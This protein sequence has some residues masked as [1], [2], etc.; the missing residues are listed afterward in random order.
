MKKLFLNLVCAM[1]FLPFC[2]GTVRSEYPLRSPVLV[3]SSR[4]SCLFCHL[5]ISLS[6]E[7]RASACSLV[8]RRLHR[9][10]SSFSCRRVE[11]VVCVRSVFLVSSQ[12]FLVDPSVR[13]CVP[14]KDSV[15]S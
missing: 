10:L 14:V 15:L 7:W 2:F 5:D 3:L 9:F 13:A 12:V 8:V 6:Q 11:F 4:S 1:Y